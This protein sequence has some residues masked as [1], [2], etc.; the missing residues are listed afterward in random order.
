M[1]EILDI[2]KKLLPDLVDIM[3]KRYSILHQ[4]MISRLIG[5]RTL[6]SALE[7]D[8]ACTARGN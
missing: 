7:Y 1:R 2:Q 3:Q 6:A 5:R 8:G 4:I